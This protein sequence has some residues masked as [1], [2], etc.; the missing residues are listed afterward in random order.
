MKKLLAIVSA[1]FLMGSTASAQ[2]NYKAFEHLSAG[3]GIGTTGIEIQF[4][5]PLSRQFAI[6]TGFSF[7]PAFTKKFNVDFNSDEDWLATDPATGEKIK[8]ADIKGKIL[9]AD[10]KLLADWYPFRNSTFHLTAGFFV[11]KSKLLDAHNISPVVSDEKNSLGE[12][13]YW[14]TSGPELGS[15][16]NTYTVVSDENGNITADVKVNSFKPYIG[17]GWGRPI[18]KKDLNVSFDFG[19][20]FWGK[21]GLYTKISDN[22]GQSYRKVDRNRITN[23]QDYCDDIRDAIKTAQKIVVYP[24]LTVRLSGKIF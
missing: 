16:L 7:M 1:L 20:Q 6:R 9:M 15:G 18:P 11:G 19:V 12:Y 5:A 10:W 24:T 13:M 21:P 4:A 14:G 17:I 8:D 23:D 3:I 2:D 22:D